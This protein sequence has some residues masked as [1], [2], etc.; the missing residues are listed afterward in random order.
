LKTELERGV[1]MKKSKIAILTDSSSSIYSMEHD[2]EHLFMLDLPCF[3]GDRV[4]TNFMKNK[5]EEFYE[6]LR[7]SNEIA[8]T[9]Q[10][11]IGEIL[12]MY[13]QLKELGYEEVIYLPIS[14][15]ISG[16]YG[17]AIQAKELVE[18]IAVHVVDTKRT[19]SILG[20]MALEAARM[21][22]EGYTSEEIINRMYYMRDGSTYYF[23]VNDLTPLVKNGRLSNAKSYVANILKIKPIIQLTPE[24]KI[25]G[26]ENVRTFKKALDRMIELVNEQVN[27]K[28]GHIHIAFATEDENLE[29]FKEKVHEKFPHLPIKVFKIPATVVAHTGLSALGVGYVNY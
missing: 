16:S 28:T 26:V 2:Y 14:K 5:D 8:K 23:T 9:S 3:I 10:A 6:A 24:G 29:L 22:S 11:S 7:N 1:V 19:V 25:T 27:H 4:F 12:Q 18:G 15:E 17:N 21:A 13:E 20:A